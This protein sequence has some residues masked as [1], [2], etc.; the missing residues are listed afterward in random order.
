MEDRMGDMVFLIHIKALYG[1]ARAVHGWPSV[2][3]ELRR[4]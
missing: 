2:W 3:P 4:R 1:A